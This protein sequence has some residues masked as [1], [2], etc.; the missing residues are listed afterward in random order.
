M[1]ALH[2]RQKA[3]R[4][5]WLVIPE[6]TLQGQ[7]KGMTQNERANNIPC[8]AQGPEVLLC[9]FCLLGQLTASPNSPNPRYKWLWAPIQAHFSRSAGKQAGRMLMFLGKLLHGLWMSRTAGSLDLLRGEGPGRQL[10][11]DFWMPMTIAWPGS[12]LVEASGQQHR[13]QEEEGKH[14]TSSLERDPLSLAPT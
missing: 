10:L 2:R 9:F 12:S 3:G 14:H 1:Q 11:A 7:V 13:Q 8:I 5:Q 6:V 4:S